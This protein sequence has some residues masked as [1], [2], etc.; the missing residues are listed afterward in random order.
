MW[1]SS[2]LRSSAL[3]GMQP[4]VEADAA[5]VLLLHD[6]DLEAELGGTDGGDV[7]ARAGAQHDDV[8]VLAHGRRASDLT[9]RPQTGTSST[10]PTA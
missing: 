3:D 4:D 5:P 9:G 7:A 1:A 6:G 2:A 8:E 10:A